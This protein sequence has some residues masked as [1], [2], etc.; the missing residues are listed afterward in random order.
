MGTKVHKQRMWLRR[1]LKELSCPRCEVSGFVFDA[2][3]RMKELGCH[4]CGSRFR[5]QRR[6]FREWE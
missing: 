5:Q 2:D 3:G 1:R 6:S 4:S